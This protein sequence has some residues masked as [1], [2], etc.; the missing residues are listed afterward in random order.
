MEG[1]DPP[2]QERPVDPGEAGIP[3]HLGVPSDAGTIRRAYIILIL[4]VLLIFGS[5][6]TVSYLEKDLAFEDIFFE[7][8]S[9]TG[10]AGLSRGITGALSP[11]SKL[12][13]CFLMFSGKI[14]MF[15]TATFLGKE[16]STYEYR[17]PEQSVMVG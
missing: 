11:G 16:N 7:V 15:T 4:S 5:I 1:G 12:L 8:F 13:I 2:A 3:D 6:L 9:A 14:G 10:T 17:Y